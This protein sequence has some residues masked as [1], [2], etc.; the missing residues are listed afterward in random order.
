MDFK[1]IF[2]Y[3]LAT[4]K[5]FGIVTWPMDFKLLFFMF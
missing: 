3:V 1:L 4:T 5:T 2:F